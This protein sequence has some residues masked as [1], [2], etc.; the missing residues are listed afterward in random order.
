M[1][2]LMLLS[3]M[4]AVLAAA[5]VVVRRERRPGPVLALE[6][7]AVVDLAFLRAAPREID[8]RT[9]P[10]RAD[11]QGS[12]GERM[13]TAQLAAETARPVVRRRRRERPRVAAR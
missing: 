2:D 1:L 10:L 11:A 12:L 13:R 9:T 3:P 7:A 5:A 8:L 4:A 6:E